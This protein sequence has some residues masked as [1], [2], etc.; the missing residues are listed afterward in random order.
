MMMM[1]ML[2]LPLLAATTGDD[3][4]VVGAISD[5]GC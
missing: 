4:T 3:E 2:R 5:L 1:I